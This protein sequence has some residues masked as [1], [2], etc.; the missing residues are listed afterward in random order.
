MVFNHKFFLFLLILITFITP[1]NAFQLVVEPQQ[2][3]VYA[4][5]FSGEYT[6]LTS[7]VIINIPNEALIVTST[8]AFGNVQLNRVQ[9]IDIVGISLVNSP[10]ANQSLNL[11]FYKYTTIGTYQLLDSTTIASNECNEYCEKLWTLSS[12]VPV[13]SGVSYAIGIY[14]ADTNGS[15]YIY[16]DKN[17]KYFFNLPSIT[18][19]QTIYPIITYPNVST[20][21]NQEVG[22]YIE[23]L[24]F[25]LY[26]T[27]IYNYNELPPP[28]DN[29]SIGEAPCDDCKEL[30]GYDPNGTVFIPD[31]SN[32]TFCPNCSGNETHQVVGNLVPTSGFCYSIQ[33]FGYGNV[34]G[35]SFND[36]VDILYDSSNTLF[37]LSCS[38]LLYKI[39]ILY[40]NRSKQ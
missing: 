13:E 3:N 18:S 20:P 40:K 23:Y 12:S 37:W 39:Y 10:S 31:F 35:C 4:Y 11:R 17:I 8:D 22:Y 30:I 9:S 14:T 36:F 33:M 24:N 25:K 7:Q 15:W 32:L 6:D 1:V 26:G 5:K 38:L 21:F 16:G 28:V 27:W 29:G 34:D 2:A 19:F